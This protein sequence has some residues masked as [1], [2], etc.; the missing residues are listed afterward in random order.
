MT[1][2]PVFTAHNEIVR[3]QRF[4]TLAG[5]PPGA[6]VAGHKK[7]VVISVKL[8]KAPGKVAIYGWHRVGGV[9]IQPLY[10]GHGVSWV[11][12]S[13]GVRLVDQAMRVNGSTTTVAR[14]L[15]DPCLAGLLSDEGVVAQ[16]RYSTEGFE[17]SHRG[18]RRSPV[19][20]VEFKSGGAYGERTAEFAIEP[21]V[22]VHFN[23]PAVEGCPSDRP[24]LLV[25]YALP[26]GNTTAQT[27]GQIGRAQV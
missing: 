14:V 8:E 15:S 9:P 3:T 24:V 17:P 20:G 27:I 10:L 21:G 26:N 7:D 19:D 25:L 18:E 13:H 11:D 2:V 1:T 23:A 16:P 6:L 5:H 12:Y 22:K 4:E